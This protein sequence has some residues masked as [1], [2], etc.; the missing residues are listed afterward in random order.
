MSKSNII[1]IIYACVFITF[2]YSCPC[3]Q[4]TVYSNFGPGHEGWDYNFGLGWTVAGDSVANQYGVEQAMQFQSNIDGMVTD[5]W[6]AFFYVPTSPPPDTVT[7]RLAGNPDAAPPVPEDVLEEWTIT[8]FESWDQ[9]HPPI[10]LQGGNV[11]LLEEGKTYW[12]WAIAGETTWCGWCLNID[13]ALT[14]PHTLRR[15][16]ED[17]L[18]IQQ[19]TA[20]AFRIDVDP[21]IDIRLIDN[22]IP[23][24]HS[25]SKN[26]PNP[27]NSRTTIEYTLPD[28]GPVTIDIYNLLGSKLETLVNTV[29][30]AG[31]HSVTLNADG[32]SSGTY[33]YS[34]KAGEYSETR[35][36]TLVK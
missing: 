6:V 4:V 18:P 31:E 15:E 13:P 9:W 26:Y 24:S 17:W 25:L 23:H 35:K 14:C 20:S 22:D 19:E 2:L 29:Q 36:M 16:G 11:A 12:L 28:A 32:Y 3:A 5:I 7:I 10:H 8:E 1:A 21:S 27:F 33:F 34:I 30:D